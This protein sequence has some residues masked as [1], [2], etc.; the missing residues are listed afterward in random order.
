[1]HPQCP[2]RLTALA[3][4]AL[5]RRWALLDGMASP[6]PAVARRVMESMMTMQKIDVATIEAGRSGDVDRP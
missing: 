4:D 1:V 3:H 6:D 2:R 5:D